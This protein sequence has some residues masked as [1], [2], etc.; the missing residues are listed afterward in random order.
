MRRFDEALD[1]VLLRAHDLIYEAREPAREDGH[2]LDP[3][4]PLRNLSRT[5][6][7]VADRHGW[8]AIVPSDESDWVAFL[9]TRR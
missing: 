2:P 3:T 9:E 4:V 6:D 8:R 7:G 1:Y 5:L